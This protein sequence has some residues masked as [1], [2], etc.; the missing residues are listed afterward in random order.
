M[1]NIIASDPYNEL[2]NAYTWTW[3]KLYNENH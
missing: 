1:E 2:S 3:T